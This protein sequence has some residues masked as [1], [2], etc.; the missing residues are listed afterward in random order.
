[1]TNEQYNPWTVT[2]WDSFYFLNCPECVYRLIILRKC[3]CFQ[4]FSRHLAEYSTQQCH[5]R[6]SVINEIKVCCGTKQKDKGIVLS[7]SCILGHE[8]QTLPTT[9]KYCLTKNQCVQI[10]YY[11]IGNML[12]AITNFKIHQNLLMYQFNL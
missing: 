12:E 5:P 11:S 9:M 4:H 1:M 6:Q 8:D 2:S 7:R 10:K 3:C